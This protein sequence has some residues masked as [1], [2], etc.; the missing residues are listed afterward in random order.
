MQQQRAIPSQNPPLEASPPPEQ[1]HLL[2]EILLTG[3]LDPSWGTRCPLGVLWS[4]ASV[5][6]VTTESFP[7]ERAP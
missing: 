5:L 6:V 2:E 4:L 1:G 3:F 7:A